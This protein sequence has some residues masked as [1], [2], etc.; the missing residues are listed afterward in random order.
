[1]GQLGER[2]SAMGMWREGRLG[3][4]RASWGAPV[5]LWDALTMGVV[6]LGVRCGCMVLGDWSDLR[7]ETA[8]RP[9]T[10]AGMMGEVLEEQGRSVSIGASRAKEP[11]DIFPDHWRLGRWDS[12]GPVVKTGQRR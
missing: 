1:M 2:S 11:S 8:P 12:R 4:M 5:L 10:W 7:R 9:K 3:W 6:V